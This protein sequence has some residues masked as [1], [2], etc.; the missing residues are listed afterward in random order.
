MP[1]FIDLL[2]HKLTQIVDTTPIQLILS[3]EEHS[4]GR[5]ADDF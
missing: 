1:T 5:A 4:E 3:R 2:Q